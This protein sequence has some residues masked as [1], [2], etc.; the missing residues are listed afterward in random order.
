MPTENAS[1]EINFQKPKVDKKPRSGL[2]IKMGNKEI[3]AFSLVGIILLLLFT[4]LLIR[5]Q[6]PLPAG[7]ETPAPTPSP[8]IIEPR[9]ASS[10]ASDSAILKIE[11]ALKKTEGEI[12]Q[13]D[14]YE[15]TLNPPLL[16][17]NVSF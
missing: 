12:Q 9:A 4:L 14:F 2:K 5:S 6:S 15:T 16:D 7:T 13:T 11:E 8:V 10:Y 17:L 3:L 1:T